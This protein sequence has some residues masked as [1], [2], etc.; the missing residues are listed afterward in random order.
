MQKLS[1]EHE[2]TQFLKKFDGQ[3]RIAP[4]AMNIHVLM[5]ALADED[6]DHRQL[7]SVL[8]HYP[9]ITARLIALANSAWVCPVAPI[10]NIET[11]CVRLG[12]S[13]VKGVSI[14]IAV[15][16]SFNTARCPSFDP[17]RFWTTSMLVAEGAG[18][19]ADK[20]P[21]K[22]TYPPDLGHTAQTGGVL[23]NLGLLW[24]ADNLASETAEALQLLLANPNLTVNQALEQQIGI[25]YCLVG[26]WIAKQW[27]IPEPLIAVMQHHRDPNYQEQSFALVSLVGGAAKMVSNVFHSRQELPENSAL[28]SLGLDLQIQ[29]SVFTQLANRLDS[30]QKLATALFF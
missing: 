18:L 20:L 17:I 14:A 12:S 19:L 3:I 6:M 9:V 27:Q 23:H 2:L 16:S 7:A 24:L 10:T 26:A 4:L 22:A 30:T 28:P 1:G 11:A 5:Q 13:V 15:A 25:D 29:T 8:H 21:N